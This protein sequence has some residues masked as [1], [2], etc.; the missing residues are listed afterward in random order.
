MIVAC[1]EAYILLRLACKH[2]VIGIRGGSSEFSSRKDKAQLYPAFRSEIAMHVGDE[3]EPGE[4]VLHWKGKHLCL[5]EVFHLPGLELGLPRK[6]LHDLNRCF[7]KSLVIWGE[8]KGVFLVE[9]KLTTDSMDVTHSTLFF[10][11]PSCSS[12]PRSMFHPYQGMVVT[13]GLESTVII[14]SSWVVCRRETSP[15]LLATGATPNRQT[16][17]WMPLNACTPYLLD[18]L[19]II[20]HSHTNPFLPVFEFS[21]PES[22]VDLLAT[23][24]YSVSCALGQELTDTIQGSGQWDFPYAFTRLI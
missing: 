7:R 24:R 19:V 15:F 11:R 14:A 8:G 23:R 18:C 10:A 20:Q 1:F 5:F 13:R 16:S 17:P 3:D 12:G 4:E 9:Q 6:N 22:D 21:S 2:A